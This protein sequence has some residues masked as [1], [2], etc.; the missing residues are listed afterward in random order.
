MKDFMSKTSFMSILMFDIF[1]TRDFTGILRVFG[2]SSDTTTV[3]VALHFGQCVTMATLLLCKYISSKLFSE[4]LAL[5]CG[6]EMVFLM[7][8]MISLRLLK[9]IGIYKMFGH[10]YYTEKTLESNFLG[11]VI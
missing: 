3:V 1:F 2:V 6:Q 5:Q 4:K 8:F 7:W 11:C 10:Q 9:N